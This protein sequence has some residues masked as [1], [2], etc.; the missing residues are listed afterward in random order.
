MR[1]VAAESAA[2]SP[3]LT[4]SIVGVVWLPASLR[5]RPAR[6]ALR[7]AEPSRMPCIL[8]AAARVLISRVWY[9]RVGDS[10]YDPHGKSVTRGSTVD[11][12]QR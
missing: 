4:S 11:T 10:D 5:L 9:T 3:E 6:R 2:K 8:A 1:S 7:N 12:H